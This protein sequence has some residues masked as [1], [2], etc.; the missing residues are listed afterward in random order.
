MSGYFDIGDLSYG[1]D[2]KVF[3]KI[4]SSLGKA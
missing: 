2:I 3:F 1:I 4:T